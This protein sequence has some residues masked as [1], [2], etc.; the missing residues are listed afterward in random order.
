MGF[1]VSYYEL[2][3]ILDVLS[4]EGE[5]VVVSPARLQL[6]RHKTLLHVVIQQGVQQI[7]RDTETEKIVTHFFNL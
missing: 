1:R 2:A 6:P 4:A 5:R 3:D 7:F